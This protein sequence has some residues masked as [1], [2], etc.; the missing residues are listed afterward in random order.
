MTKKNR[1]GKPGKQKKPSEKQVQCFYCSESMQRKAL[2]KHMTRFH[3]GQPVREKGTTSLF[4][5]SQH[6]LKRRRIEPE[7]SRETKTKTTAPSPEAKPDSTSI[8]S[9]ISTTFMNAVNAL[10][11]LVSSLRNIAS[12]LSNSATQ[13]EKLHSE[14]SAR[15]E[16]TIQRYKSYSEFAKFHKSEGLEVF[17][18]GDSHF[19]RC[20]RCTKHQKQLRNSRTCTFVDTW[21]VGKELE[22]R[23]EQLWSRHI[24]TKMHKEAIGL[25]SQ[26]KL[27]TGFQIASNKVKALT[28]NFFRYCYSSI[29]MGLSYRQ[30][31]RFISTLK[32]SGFEVGNRN[33]DQKA[34][35]AA[36]DCMYDT[37]FNRLRSYFAS[38]NPC[39]NQSRKF[40][41]SADKG[42]E[43]QQRQVINIHVFD[44]DGRLI[45]LHLTAHLVNEV[46]ISDSQAEE[47]TAKALMHHHIEQLKLADL[48]IERIQTSWVNSCTDAEPCYVLM[49]KKIKKEIN[50]GFFPT[51]DA[52]HS[53]ESLFDDVEK[54][55]QWMSNTLSIID[56]VHSRY[57]GSPKKK[58]KLRRSASVFKDVYVSLKRI[59]ETRY[60]KFSVVA[61]DALLKMLRSV[62]FVL[63]DDWE[64]TNDDGAKGLLREIYSFDTIPELMALLDVLDHP[65]AFSVAS[66]AGNFTVFHFLAR[67]RNFISKIRIMA[68][69]GFS[70]D[71]K[72]GSGKYLSQRLHQHQ[73]SILKLEVYGIELGQHNLFRAG[74]SRSNVMKSGRE[75]LE[76]CLRKQREF[77][78][79]ILKHMDRLPETEILIAIEKCFDPEFLMRTPYDPKVYDGLLR[80][81]AKTFD[82]ETIIAPIIVGHAEFHKILS[83][84]ENQ[85]KYGSYWDANHGKKNKFNSRFKWDPLGVIE[86]FMNPN[87]GL[88]ENLYDFCTILEHVGL[89]R[90]TQSDTE[91]VV[92]TQRKVESRFA[93]YNELKEAEGKRDRAKQ[94]IFL[95]EN[96]IALRELPFEEFNLNWLKSHLPSLKNNRKY[97]KDV[98]GKSTRNFFKEDRTKAK[99]LSM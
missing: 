71:L 73:E 46:D 27:M 63:E 15:N 3:N 95:K 18:A 85:V 1:I 56:N 50:P 94:E 22:N 77:C 44:A 16:K 5:F 10:G 96:P 9:S 34:A 29:R 64:S 4:E 91:R 60:I 48:G 62:S 40:S 31:I 72:S 20:T 2:A 98:V 65:V 67:R 69:E 32:E 21:V 92:K 53:I 28:L 41:T 30:L 78:K 42:T 38:T 83:Q 37:V 39:T 93:G 75:V 97:V 99:F 7:N 6:T 45:S 86:S 58:R 57:S 24:N 19:G 51:I 8:L 87:F 79:L 25:D 76:N 61:G 11:T 80:L 49:G 23:R 90:F 17:L 59:V 54:E 13:L 55:S 52:A 81:L 74:R 82:M 66:Q 70:I 68:T 89:I 47:S 43:L 36:C 12:S 33:H 14:K 26:L 84:S 88:H 35:A